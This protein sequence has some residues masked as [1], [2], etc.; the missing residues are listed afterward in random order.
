MWPDLH[1]SNNYK[2]STFQN[3]IEDM[4]CTRQTG[5]SKQASS[6]DQ[7]KYT[8]LTE[9][10]KNTKISEKDNKQKIY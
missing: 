10:R 4:E 9:A 6:K 8:I 1:L 2:H 5:Q 3:C 7:N